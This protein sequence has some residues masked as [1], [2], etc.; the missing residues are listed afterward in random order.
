VTPDLR[1]PAVDLLTSIAQPEDV[2]QQACALGVVQ[3]QGKVDSYALLMVV[4]LGLVVRGRVSIAQLGQIYGDV[5]GRRL[6]RSSFWDRLTPAFASLVGWLLDRVVAQSRRDAPRPPGILA[7]FKDVLAAD[8]SVVKVHDSLRG[9]WKGTRRNSAK[10]ALKVHAWIRVFTGELVKYRITPE[11]YGDSRAF[12]IDHALRGTLMLFD[13]GYAS[14]SLWRRIDSV[15]G[16]F[17]TRIPK[18]WNQVI[19]SENRRHRGC[20]RSLAGKTLNDALAGLQRRIVDVNVT[21]HCRVRGYGGER[22]RKVDHTFRVVALRCPSGEYALYVTNAPSEM[23]PAEDL[24]NVYRLRWEV[25]TFFKTAKSGCAL[26]ETPSRSRHR[27]ETLVCA[28]L[29]RAT[30]A[31]MAKARFLRLVPA[32]DRVRVNPH[33]WMRWWIRQL[34]TLLGELVQGEPPLDMADL[35]LTLADP[36]KARLPMRD[37]FTRTG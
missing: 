26:S 35:L 23:L 17:L 5:T 27:V 10:A 7:G 31:M 36:N 34:D 20:A 28:A 12:G 19:A 32:R 22:A 14:P 9:V 4:V 30:V 24:R 18:G 37:A 21:F 8:S 16:Y 33:Q 2:R 15:G 29:L 3:R 13:R 6:A 25:E 1:T 11:A